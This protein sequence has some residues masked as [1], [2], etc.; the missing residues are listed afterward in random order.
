MAIESENF[1]AGGWVQCSSTYHLTDGYL[2]VELVIATTRAPGDRSHATAAPA[3][4]GDIP[5]STL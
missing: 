2:I 5:A 4:G 3:L 1:R